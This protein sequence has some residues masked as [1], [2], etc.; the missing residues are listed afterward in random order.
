M[1]HHSLEKTGKN[2]NLYKVIISESDT[3]RI[4]HESQ[5]IKNIIIVYTPPSDNLQLS[6]S[7]ILGMS[8]M[9]QYRLEGSS[10]IDLKFNFYDSITDNPLGV[11]RIHIKRVKEPSCTLRKAMGSSVQL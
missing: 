2:R 4:N 10:Q 3:Q 8:L 7:E 1:K 9:S 11:S 5:N 6:L